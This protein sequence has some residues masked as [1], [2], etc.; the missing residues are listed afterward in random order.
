MTE[1]TVNTKIN[2]SDR[3]IAT[4]RRASSNMSF[5]DYAKAAGLEKEFIFSILKGEIEEVDNDTLRKLSLV[6]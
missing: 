1:E 3:L 2:N 5:E 4:I 6:H